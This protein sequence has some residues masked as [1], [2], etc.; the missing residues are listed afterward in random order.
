M[1]YVPWIEKVILC[2]KTAAFI[3]QQLGIIWYL[4]IIG[5]FMVLFIQNWFQPFS[6]VHVGQLCTPTK[7]GKK[8]TTRS[9]W[10]HLASE[11][12][13]G[14]YTTKTTFRLVAFSWRLKQFLSKFWRSSWSGSRPPR[15]STCCSSGWLQ[16]ST[17]NYQ[18]SVSVTTLASNVIQ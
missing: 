14:F 9:L 2:A 4:S 6:F 8:L 10:R 13:R 1:H 5:I 18:Q 15:H 16:R 17:S 7:R 3:K 12:L 11:I